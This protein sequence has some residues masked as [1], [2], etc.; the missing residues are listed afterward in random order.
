MLPKTA[1]FC[2][3]LLDRKLE[4]H[5]LGK[6]RRVALPLPSSVC[7]LLLAAHSAFA[8]AWT[9]T[10]APSN[11]WTSIALSA[12]GSRLAAVADDVQGI[13]TSTNSGATWT[14]NSFPAD[15]NGTLLAASADGLHL[16]A[17]TDNSG[18]IDV[19]TNGGMNWKK[20][21][22][23]IEA[24]WQ[25]LV[26]SS[27]GTVLVLT[28]DGATVH[29]STNSG[30]TWFPLAELP[31]SGSG[32]QYAVMSANASF[33]GVIAQGGF[34]T[35]TNFGMNWTT[36][37]LSLN[38]IARTIVGSADGSKLVTAPYGN[39]IF[40]S[41]NFGASWTQ[42]T[43]SPNLLWWSCASSAD[44]TKLAAVC[45][46]AG[47]ADVI[48]TS[49]D[50]GTTWASNSVPADQWSDIVSSADGNE[51]FAI[52]TGSGAAPRAGVWTL[53]TTPSPQL[54]LSTSNGA[55]TFSWLVPST[56][57]VLQESPDLDNWIAL[58]NLPALNLTN[59]QDQLTLAPGANN[60]DFFRLISQ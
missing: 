41:T 45:G 49:T 4:R 47:G 38:A 32:A 58:T 24:A 52:V 36:N 16:V 5:R 23:Y 35:T 53:Q 3:F 10:S 25:S 13:Y 31:N 39:N 55:L 40:T 1:P 30:A 11:Y 2:H 18:E 9:Q 37:S 14:S 7:A 59:L 26:S 48:Y 43:N 19:S 27:D 34:Y 15:V 33:L 54:N 20:S 29:A 51:L 17:A 8:Q 6:M 57:F 60:Q 42:E 56:N 21:T 50:S 12:D 46:A 44:G 22:N 28:E